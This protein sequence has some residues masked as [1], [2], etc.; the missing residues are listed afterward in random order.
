MNKIICYCRA[1]LEYGTAIVFHRDWP[2]FEARETIVSET[3]L[4][5]EA[6]EISLARTF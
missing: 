1:V 2:V 3:S 4:S 5:L 6:K